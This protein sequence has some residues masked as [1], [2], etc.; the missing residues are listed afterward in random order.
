MGDPGES[1]QGDLAGGLVFGDSRTRFLEGI[2]TLNNRRGDSATLVDDN[3]AGARFVGDRIGTEGF[4]GDSETVPSFWADSSPG[5]SEIRLLRRRVD[6]LRICFS[7]T[8]WLCSTGAA[9]DGTSNSISG[10]KSASCRVDI[11]VFGSMGHRVLWRFLGIH[12]GPS[13]SHITPD[14]LVA[15]ASM[16][17]E[18]AAL[19]SI[20]SRSPS[21]GLLY[22]TS[23]AT[24][25]KTGMYCAARMRFRATSPWLSSSV[26]VET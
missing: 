18:T 21:T 20:K 9:A 16:A 11:V 17:A 25:P 1:L 19:A 8:C 14:A 26:M 5:A 6:L 12:I 23:H 13:L 22:L 15:A 10:C 2:S 3:V 24:S 4:A 7:S